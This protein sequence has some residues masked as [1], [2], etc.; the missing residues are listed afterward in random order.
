[1]GGENLSGSVTIGPET[2]KDPPGGTVAW[3]FSNPNYNPQSG[4]VEIIIIPAIASLTVVTDPAAVGGTTGSGTHTVDSA[5][6]I[7]APADVD[8]V[9][10][11][12]GGKKK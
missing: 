1:M 4:S 12:G 3:S 11:Y 10:H 9:I 7:S 8:I 6:L 5:V 2:Y